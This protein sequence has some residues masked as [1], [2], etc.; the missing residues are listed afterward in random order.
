[1]KENKN[2]INFSYKFLA[3]MTII[4][5]VYAFVN[6]E[7]FSN[8][9]YRF[10]DIIIKILPLM[11]IVVAVMFVVNKFITPAVIKKHLGA[12]SG[13]RA[14]FYTTLAGI[15][16]SG[17]PYVLF[18]LLKELKDKG[19][20]DKFIAIFLYNRNIKI[21][22]LPAIIYYFG[23]SFTIILFFYII[24]FS[25][26]SGYLIEKISLNRTIKLNK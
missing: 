26:I 4:Y 20:S 25:F 8:T 2:N 12:E 14:Y 17:P 24:V 21:P 9:W 7:A 1:M 23:T 19:M 5:T 6:F 11:I 22:F 10:L 3:L 15:L 13:F 18:P 16:I